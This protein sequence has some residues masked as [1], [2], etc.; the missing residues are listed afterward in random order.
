MLSSWTGI[1]KEL[2]THSEEVFQWKDGE[3]VNSSPNTHK[4][5]P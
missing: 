1:R 5:L 4:R 3:C 2:I